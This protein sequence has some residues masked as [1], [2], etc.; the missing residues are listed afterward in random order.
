MIS[1]QLVYNC[2]NV[3]QYVSIDKLG[4][5]SFDYFIP[6]SLINQDREIV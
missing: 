2:L 3:I 1:V 5:Q 6:K 4:F